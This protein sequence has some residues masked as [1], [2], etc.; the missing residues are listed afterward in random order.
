M[1]NYTHSHPRYRI[2]EHLKEE[3][4]Y[5]RS[6]SRHLISARIEAARFAAWNFSNSYSIAKFYNK[7]DGSL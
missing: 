2:S 6:T 4:V 5:T 1:E 3:R 7:E